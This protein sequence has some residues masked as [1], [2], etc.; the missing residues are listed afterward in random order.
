M[1]E[2]VAGVASFSVATP[3]GPLWT[4]D[5]DDFPLDVIAG[6]QR[7]SISSISGASSP[8]TFTVQASGHTI[9]YPIPASSMVVVHQPIILTL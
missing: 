1:P 8:Q 2:E 5:A 3:S 4:T 6:G 7:V 9:V